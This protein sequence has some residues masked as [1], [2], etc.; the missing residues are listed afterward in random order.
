MPIKDRYKILLKSGD[1][2][3]TIF[4]SANSLIEAEFYASK[5]M[6]D[7]NFKNYNILTINA[8]PEI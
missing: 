6:N 5:Y 2:I 1:N 7:N 8:I 3:I 4:C